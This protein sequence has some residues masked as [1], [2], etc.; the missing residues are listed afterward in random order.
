MQTIDS[1][2]QEAEVGTTAAGTSTASA[3][4]PEG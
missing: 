1:D 3:V 4:V 2:H